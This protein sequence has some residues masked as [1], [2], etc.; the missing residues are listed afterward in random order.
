MSISM[1]WQS[2]IT[3]LL[4]DI[5]VIIGATSLLYW[6]NDRT[7]HS[8][9]VQHRKLIIGLGGVAYI[10]LLYALQAFH[11]ALD[12]STAAFGLH[13][14]FLNLM[15]L[16]MYLIIMETGSWLEV[17]LWIT[18]TGI[19]FFYYSSPV[20]IFGVSAYLVWATILIILRQR[21]Q[22][23][24]YNRTA[25]YGVMLAF[26]IAGFLTIY[27]MYPR[28]FDGWFIVRQFTAYVVLGII[29]GEFSRLMVAT[30]RREDNL[31][32]RASHD[33]L[34]A[35][36]NVGT[37]NR[38][39]LNL[40]RQ[41]KREHDPFTMFEIDLDHFKAIN[42]QYGHLKGNV[43]LQ[44]VAAELQQTVKQLDQHAKAYRL[45]GEE[46]CLIVQADLSSDDVAKI[47][48]AFQSR[49]AQLQLTQVDAE[50]K[51]TT[52]IGCATVKPQ[53]NKYFDVYAEA[54]RYLY[55]AKDG[56]RDLIAV[57]GDLLPRHSA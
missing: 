19:Y 20:T 31:R 49:L 33:E 4:L 40:Y 56:G 57:E 17:I 3:S 2:F 44:A 16:A 8:S 46:F 30:D 29:V 21:G 18:L 28:Q 35:L 38:D 27:A 48:L 7:I 41:F 9:I 6:V 53:H 51:L 1:V 10:G 23:I 37:F 52:S 42:D 11:Y 26:G 47:A 55:L 14:T 50:L 32:N 12:P 25:Y 45:G 54:D 39:T 5:L 24:K 22:V 15:L 43:V 34:T 36:A 13:W